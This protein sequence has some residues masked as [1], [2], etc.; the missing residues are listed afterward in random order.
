MFGASRSAAPDAASRRERSCRVR[1]SPWPRST[2]LGRAAAFLALG[3]LFAGLNTG[4][5]L[6][7]LIFAVL[8]AGELVGFL[9][10]GHLLRCSRVELRVASRGTAGRPLPVVVTIHNGSRRR[11]LPALR[12]IVDAG[13]A[14]GTV[15]TPPV[16]PRGSGTGSGSVTPPARGRLAVRRLEAQTDFPLGLARRVVRAVPLR[17]ASALIAPRPLEAAPEVLPRH[18]RFVPV[19]AAWRRPGE[20]PFDARPYRPGD[21][22]RR[23]DWKATARSPQVIWRDRR[24]SPPP[25]LIVRLDRS[26]PSGP[27][28]EDRVS[29][30]AGALEE[31]L[32]TGRP[33]R[34]VS[35]E[36]AVDLLDP[37]DRTAVLDYLAR[38]EP[39][40]GT[41]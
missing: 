41:P 22:A 9:A 12:W 39:V 33:A 1:V 32:R 8:A 20:E 38:V 4:N 2:P 5:N 35:D 31:A 6:F 24:G 10:A 34:F 3:L 16:P 28:F 25:E 27:A 36:I 14:R 18:R 37:A 23:I 13:G 30:A 15:V 17:E 11:T 40:G 21:D 19:A 26:G 7:D 29:R